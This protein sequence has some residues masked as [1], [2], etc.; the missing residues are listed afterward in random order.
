VTEALVAAPVRG[1]WRPATV[2]WGLATASVLLIVAAVAST[3][4]WSLGRPFA[5]YAIVIAPLHPIVGAMGRRDSRATRW[6]GC[7]SP[8]ACSR[9]RRR[10]P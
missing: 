1:L 5:S 8:S 3:V 2:A 7:S 6:G 4:A 9:E 10:S